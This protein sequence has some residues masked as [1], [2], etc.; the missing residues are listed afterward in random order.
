MNDATLKHF[1]SE[2]FKLRG[3][4]A[5]ALLAS[6]SMYSGPLAKEFL[7]PFDY[8]ASLAATVGA[9]IGLALLVIIAARGVFAATT[10]V[11]TEPPTASD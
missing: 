7:S 10:P 3:G 4:A 8:W 2:I 9:Y 11:V 5:S 6:G 1:F